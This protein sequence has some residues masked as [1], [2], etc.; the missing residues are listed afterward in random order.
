[1]VREMAVKEHSAQFRDNYG[2]LF[3]AVFVTPVAL[4]DHVIRISLSGVPRYLVVL[5][6]GSNRSTSL[7]MHRHPLIPEDPEAF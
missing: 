2:T 3:S 1:M 7:S 6:S 5:I 4:C